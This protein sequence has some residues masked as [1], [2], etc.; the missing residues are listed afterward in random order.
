M[1]EELE[2]RVGIEPTHKGFADPVVTLLSP[3]HS[4]SGW[5]PSSI[6]SAFCPPNEGKHL[7]SQRE[8]S[9]M[10]AGLDFAFIR[11]P[12]AVQVISAVPPQPLNPTAM[13]RLE[14]RPVVRSAEQLRL[15]RALEELGWTGVIDEF[16][17]AARLPNPSVPEPILITTNGTILAGFGRWRS[18]VFEA[19]HELN[20]IEYQLSEDESLPFILLDHQTRCGW[21]TFIR[22]RLAP[23]T[24]VQSS[25][26]G[27]RQHEFGGPSARRCSAVLQ[28]WGPRFTLRRIRS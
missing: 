22:I 1:L 23:D 13:N 28:S 27:A 8:C 4:T 25:A 11:S 15:H 9:A 20:C 10:S 24:G 3:F 6:L 17:D 5:K 7:S 19:R 2:A 18:A 21:N 26:E 16:N 14:G 12:S